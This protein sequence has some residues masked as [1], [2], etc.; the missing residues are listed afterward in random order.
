MYSS[1]CV[2]VVGTTVNVSIVVRVGNQSVD[3]INI[4]R[5]AGKECTTH[6]FMYTFI[7]PSLA[8]L[9]AV[10]CFFAFGADQERV[11]G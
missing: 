6:F 10:V 2:D 1:V 8:V 7:V 4:R 3:D 11:G 9:T 5:R